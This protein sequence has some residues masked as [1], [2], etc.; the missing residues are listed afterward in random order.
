MALIFGN[1]LLENT[2]GTQKLDK[3]PAW[4]NRLARTGTSMGIDDG[5]S[6]DVVAEARAAAGLKG[7]VGWSLAPSSSQNNGNGASAAK[8]SQK[9]ELTEKQKAALAKLK[10]NAR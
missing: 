1:D 10:K 3:F 5:N 7:K 8:R 2:S 6:C 9:K 4:V